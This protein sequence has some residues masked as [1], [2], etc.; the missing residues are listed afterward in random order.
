ML[1]RE[2]LVHWLDA[3][4]CDSLPDMVQVRKHSERRCVIEYILAT[5]QLRC[6]IMCV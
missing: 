3:V 1:A 2:L 4:V 5:F 6:N